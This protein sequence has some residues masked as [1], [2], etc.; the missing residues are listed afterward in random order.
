ALDEL[1]KKHWPPASAK[2][3]NTQ[4]LA[5]MERIKGVLRGGSGD[6]QKGKAIFQRCA[7]CHTLFN[8]GGK[9][10]PDLTGYERNNVDFWLTNMLDPSIEIRE[11]FGAYIC[12]L[13]DGQVLMGL[14]DKQDAGG[15]VL[16]DLAA[17]KHV[18]KQSDIESM[19]ASPISLMPEGQLNGVSDGDLRDL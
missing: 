14:I 1:V 18:V 19:E 5:E 13:K 12:K 2:L 10:G 15:I 4:K 6:P 11:G 8:E 16:K 17:Q 9:V 7:I 3:N